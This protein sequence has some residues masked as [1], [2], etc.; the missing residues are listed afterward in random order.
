MAAG[1][2]DGWSYEQVRGRN[3][4][5]AAAWVQCA[6]DAQDTTMRMRKGVIPWGAGETAMADIAEVVDLLES[7]TASTSG[8]SG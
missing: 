4:Q 1:L 6:V 8:E 7:G 2:E 5:S 3:R